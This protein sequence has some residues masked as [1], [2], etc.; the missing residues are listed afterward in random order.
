VVGGFA[1]Q[2]EGNRPVPETS[3]SLAKPI[4]V[5][6]L[7][8]GV[9]GWSFAPAAPDFETRER[10]RIQAHFDSVLTELRASDLRALD[11]NRRERRARLVEVLEAYRHRGIFPHN[12]DRPDP[13]PTF[14]DT[15]TGVRCAVAHLVDFTG[16]G[17]IVTRVAAANNRVYVM[18]LGA[19]TA[20]TGWLDHH[21]LTLAEAA[22]IQVPYM[23]DDSPMS[24][25]SG[26]V[27]AMAAMLTGGSALLGG[28]NLL[29]NS[30]GKRKLLSVAGFGMGAITAAAGAA[31]MQEQGSAAFVG[32]M[33]M[34][35]GAATAIYSATRMLKHAEETRNANAGAGARLTVAPSVELPKEASAR[36]GL[37]GRLRF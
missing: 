1:F 34:T 19:D 3:M 15:K 21:G 13:T 26:G 8:A 18:E 28:A 2:W 32:P 10:I 4:L 16:R 25:T 36:V 37:T 17:E 7:A 31:S 14:V 6:I 29:A 30:S 20:F 24:L 27:D 5:A 11:A 33:A 12:Y 23:A 9:A 35:I 22:R